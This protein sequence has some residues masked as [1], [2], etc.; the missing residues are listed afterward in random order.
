MMAKATNE[1]LARA[2]TVQIRRAGRGGR[3]GRG[4]R[5]FNMQC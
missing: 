5:W 2:V 4:D 1:D 3:E